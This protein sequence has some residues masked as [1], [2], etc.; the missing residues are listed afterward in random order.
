MSRNERTNSAGIRNGT[1]FL[2]SCARKKLPHPAKAKDIYMPSPLFAKSRAYVESTGRPWFIL[3]AKYGLLDPEKRIS[4]YDKTLN[5]MPKEKRREWAHK[6]LNKLVPHLEGINYV[7]ILAGSRYREFLEPKL[8]D[9][10][11]HVCVPMRS[12]GIGEQ[13]RWLNKSDP[14]RLIDTMRFYN[15]LKRLEKRVGGAAQVLANCNGRMNWPKRGVF[16]FYEYGETS[17]SGDGLRVVYVGTHAISTS[18]QV[19]LWTRLSQHR[20]TASYGG[21]KVNGSIFRRLVGKALAEQ[22]KKLTSWSGSDRNDKLLGSLT[23]RHICAMPFL[24]LNVDDTP[25]PKSRRAFIKHNAIALLSNY[26]KSPVDSASPNWLG[27]SS[28]SEKVRE[29]GLWNQKHV[30][31]EDYDPS[32]LDE[33][34]KRIDRTNPL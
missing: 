13:L 16:F 12:L 10:G 31:R 20:G 26:R 22:N 27:S 7:V 25:G 8:C 15:I 29:S 17:G 3:S 5:K 23:S 2:V 11:F 30:D 21:G 9:R 32:F 34:E 4:P 6:V 18:S 19:K 28:P 14:R 1:I 24:W 33:M